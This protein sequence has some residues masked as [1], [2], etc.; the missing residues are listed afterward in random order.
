MRIGLN[1]IYTALM[2]TF[3]STSY[4]FG[5]YDGDGIVDSEDLDDDN[6]GILDTEECSLHTSDYVNFGFEENGLSST[7]TFSFLN[8]NAVHGWHTTA[9][10]EVIEVWRSGHNDVS[11]QEGV[12]FVELNAHHASN[13]Y[14]WIK[15]TPGSIILWSV[16]HRGRRGI[17]T[18]EMRLG[19]SLSN[20]ESVVLMSDGKAW[21]TYSGRYT[22]PEN[23]TRTILMFEALE[24]SGAS[25]SHGNFLD[26]VALQIAPPNCDEDGDGQ[27]DHIDN[28]SDG[29]GC[30]DA[31]EGDDSYT[32]EDIDENGRLIGSVDSF[33]V[34]SVQ[35][36]GLSQDENNQQACVPD[37]DG[38][39]IPDTEE[40]ENG[41]GIV[42]EGETDPHNPD[43]DGDGLSDGIELGYPMDVDPSSTT[44]PRKADTDGDGLWDGE[45]DHNQ[46]GNVDWSETDPNRIDT[47][48][49]GNHC[50]DGIESLETGTDP[51]NP[52][53]NCGDDL[54][55]ALYEGW[56]ITQDEANDTAEESSYQDYNEPKET[57][58]GCSTISGTSIYS[59]WLT[60][61][62]FA[63]SRRRAS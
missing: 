14:Q 43:T 12:S 51:L 48:G 54:D 37:E 50:H 6:D 39:G 3:S 62:G 60:I 55:P 28:D 40:D 32:E 22:V 23:Q 21:G 7:Q 36:Q 38:D 25:L 52:N 24:S 5:D 13:I 61:M 41:N 26:N 45:E 19:A 34:I 2:L 18:A 4:A 1:F 59:F 31:L 33:G 47:D 29:D 8:Q 17:D 58:S 30:W 63:V 10:D 35:G 11:A 49:D 57:P 44:D 15:T 46:D 20:A 16:A 27:P 9:V 56:D 42:D 53:S